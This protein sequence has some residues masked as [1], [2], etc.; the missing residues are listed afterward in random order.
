MPGD[1]RGRLRAPLL[2]MI[3]EAIDNCPAELWTEINGRPAFW[4]QASLL[5]PVLYM[6]NAFRFGF[7]GITDISLALSYTIILLFVAGLFTFALHLL[8][9][10]SGLRT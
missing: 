2:D 3:G 7:L 4:Q 10:G 5:N 9:R 1:A 8:N 6:V